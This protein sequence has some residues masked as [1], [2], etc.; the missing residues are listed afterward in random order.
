MI[1][2]LLAAL[3]SAGDGPEIS[4]DRGH[5]G[6]VVILWPRISPQTEDPQIL[7][8]ARRSQEVLADLAGSLDKVANVRPMPE[9]ACPREGPGCR[10]P[11][12]SA[13]IAHQ[14]GGCAVIGLVGGAGESPTEVLGW[15]G[16]VQ[17][18]ERSVPFREPPESIVRIADFAPCDTVLATLPDR[19][20]VLTD[21]L[22]AA[23]VVPE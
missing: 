2:M 8:I 22:R 14:D 12:L 11:T 4:R 6:E 1:W 17:V 13:L 3:A 23:L 19:A 10:V 7:A 15:V 9:R 16:H 18:R 20:D 21:A 5:D